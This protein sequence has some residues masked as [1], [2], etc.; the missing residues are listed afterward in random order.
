VA[1]RIVSRYHG[2]P[3]AEQASAEFDAMFRH[4]GLPEQMPEHQ[5][6]GASIWIVK[7]LVEAGAVKTNS[8]ARRM[9]QQGGV[10][11]DDQ[12]VLAADAEITVRDGMILKVGKRTFV[13]LRHGGS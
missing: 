5:V 3:A 2:G 7:L 9:I 8:D 1:K 10:H 4:G 13:K 11:L 6:A 12:K